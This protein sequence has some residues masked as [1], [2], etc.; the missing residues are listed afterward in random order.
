VKR[1]TRKR[2]AARFELAKLLR[3]A[4]RW[5]GTARRPVRGLRRKI[6]GGRWF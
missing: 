4:G 6:I 3:Y 2:R 5:S 1:G